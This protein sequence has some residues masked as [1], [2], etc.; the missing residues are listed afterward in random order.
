[1]YTARRSRHFLLTVVLLCLT[2]SGSPAVAGEY[3]AP[4]VICEGQLQ[5]NTYTGNLFYARQELNIPARGINLDLTFSYNSGETK[6]DF[7][8]G[9]GWTHSFN[10]VYEKAGADISVKRWDGN[11]QLFTFEGGAY[12]PPVACY[13][14]LSQYQP[15]RF[16][17]R[18]KYGLEYDFADSSH[19]RVTSVRDRNG[20]TVT[21]S[22]SGGHPTLIT[23]ASGRSIILTWSADR[24][25]QI[26][27][28]ASPPR[29]I[30][31]EYSSSTQRDLIRVYDAA[32]RVTQYGYDDH[33]R[34]LQVTDWRGIPYQIAYTD[35]GA[36]TRVQSPLSD[37]RF[38]Y[39][40]AHR[41]T[42]H[43]L[44]G[45]ATV[46]VFDNSARITEI[47]GLCCGYH[48]LF[49]WDDANNI[50]TV[51]D[52]NNNVTTYSY[53]ARGNQLTTTDPLTYTTT[54]TYEPVFNQVTSVTDQA[55]N[56]TALTYDT[57]GNCTALT[58]P[59]DSTFHFSYDSF[60]QVSSNTDARG[61]TTTCTYND[62]GYRTGITRPIG[63]EAFTYD[64]VGNPLT[65]TD[66]NGNTTTNT[67]DALDRLTATENALSEITTY[68]FDLNDNVVT[69]AYPNENVVTAAY[70]ALN[71]PTQISDGIGIVRINS[72]DGSGNLLS[73]VDGNGNATSLTYDAQS[74]VTSVTR[75]GIP[76]LFTYDASGNMLTITDGNGHT[77]TITYD[78]LNRSESVSRGGLT[79][80]TG[81]DECGNVSWRIDAMGNRTTYAYDALSRLIQATYPDYS[82]RQYAYDGNDNLVSRI[83]NSGAMTTYTYDANG[84]LTWRHFPVEDDLYTYDPAGRMLTANNSQAAIAF[85]Y[86]EADRVLSETTNGHTTGYSYNTAARERVITYPGGSIAQELHNLRGRL[87]SLSRDD[88][89]IAFAY[90]PGG[91]LSSAS[92]GD[93]HTASYQYDNRDLMTALNHRAGGELLAGFTYTYDDTGN[94]TAAIDNYDLS[95]SEFY[96]YNGVNWLTTAQRGTPVGDSLTHCSAGA[97]PVSVSPTAVLP[98]GNTTSRTAPELGGGDSTW[99]NYDYAGNWTSVKHGADL[100][101]YTSNVLNQY[102]SSDPG[103]A[104][105]YDPTGNLTTSSA[106]TGAYDYE[107]R[108]VHGEVT[109]PPNEGLYRYDALGRRIQKAVGSETI[110]YY[111]DGNRV[112]EER[113]ASDAVT[114]TYGYGDEWVDDRLTMTHQGATYCYVTNALGS[115]V[116]MT[117]VSGHVVE[118]YQYDAFGTPTIWDGVYSTTRTRSVVGNRFLFTG[119]EY[120]AEIGLYFYRDRHY[121]PWLGRF[122]QRDPIGVWSDAR[123]PGNSHAYVGN[124]PI[125]YVDPFG[126]GPP[127]ALLNGAVGAAAALVLEKDARILEKLREKY[128][129]PLDALKLGPLAPR[130]GGT[131]N[132][133][134]V[135]SSFRVSACQVSGPDKEDPHDTFKD[136]K[137]GFCRVINVCYACC[138]RGAV[139][140]C[141]NGCRC[142]E[143]HS[144]GGSLDWTVILTKFISAGAEVA[145]MIL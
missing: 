62:N 55:G 30:A 32:G 103:G 60:G 45:R 59:L 57:H 19:K 86:D 8:Y 124:N 112:I 139:A 78:A 13:D 37:E 36:V 51:T 133:A 53:D 38:T 108:L 24:M 137:G 119:R 99:F 5:V 111:Y 73:T 76:D 28:C 80:F 125:N 48:R 64:A 21:L 87:I 49:A 70:D 120:D 33:K 56:T 107:C 1:M 92:Y 83:D 22:Y 75:G 91:R 66:A 72:F 65:H 96:G 95:R 100:T 18:A 68:A 104:F 4:N 3:T 113:N 40:T 115:V 46:Y 69:T 81:Y 42:T 34:L 63:T 10:I 142:I 128:V 52:A 2:L 140:D 84:E 134:G 25:T 39:D 122:M 16:R 17:L 43:S 116:A 44:D 102:T 94:R 7:G 131:G 74:R 61:N 106:F 89:T 126:D 6:Y 101:T 144:G 9:A 35:S 117:D 121:A 132:S 110:I 90:D 50:T 23:D 15:G 123:S 71:R 105:G 88:V 138:G 11:R 54:L 12:R 141:S 47:T 127:E 77:T 29:T 143:K 31:Y 26:T 67:Y 58:R 85:T 14:S 136:C 82:Y 145:R 20:N 118:R 41:T 79:T 93:N 97:S 109:S 98:E 129:T 27:D 130:S 114:L 135:G